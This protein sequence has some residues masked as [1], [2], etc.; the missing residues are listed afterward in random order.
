[1]SCDLSGGWAPTLDVLGV[2]LL[3]TAALLRFRPAIRHPH[4]RAL[5]L[6]VVAAA[7]AMT[8]NLQPVGDHLASL[9]GSARWIAV[10][11]NQAGIV[12]AGA[13]LHFAVHTTGRRRSGT[14]LLAT[15]AVM[16]VLLA[17][18]AL[19][20]GPEQHH[21][22]P[23][24][25]ARDPATAYWLLV[26]AAHTV[27]CA[28]C[29]RVC[30][31]YGRRGTNR[32]LN[33]S[34]GLFGWGTALVGAFWLGHLV[35][36]AADSTPGALHCFL[37]SLHA[38]LRAAA[39]LVPSFLE[40]RR[41]LAHARTVWRIWPLWKDLVDAVPQ[42]ELGESSSRVL[43]LLQPHL[44]WRLVAY[45]KSIEIRDALLALAQYADPAISGSARAHVARHMARH[46]GPPDRALILVTACELRRARAAKLAGAA[47]YPAADAL[48]LSQ[49]T[50][51]LAAETAYLRLLAE[52]YFSPC[53]EQFDGAGE[54]AGVDA[55]QAE[56][57]AEAEEAQGEEGTEEAAPAGTGSGPG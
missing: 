9:T 14:V 22:P 46:G 3:W 35:L 8:I 17:L 57:A 15:V 24:T 26:I 1:M 36:L 21:G 43:T 49:D 40:L 53:A 20:R 54:E 7:A 18:A 23:F 19:A 29:V 27:A 33:L 4:Q 11:K 10:T 2:C 47:P 51:D 37:L 44:S 31:T 25:L 34:L 39:L 30:W 5:W 55:E 38:V 50:G 12:S 6:A 32:S 13:V 56:E 28:A 41:A 45:R 48:A 42:V 16:A 52:A